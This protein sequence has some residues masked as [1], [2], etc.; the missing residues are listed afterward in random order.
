MY[1]AFLVAQSLTLPLPSCGQ[2]LP[3]DLEQQEIRDT[4]PWASLQLGYWHIS[5]SRPLASS[6]GVS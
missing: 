2:V 3:S 4:L 5:Q 6:G 1:L